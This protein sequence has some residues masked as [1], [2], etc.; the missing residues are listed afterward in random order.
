MPKEGLGPAASTTS[1][2][3]EG[4]GQVDQDTCGEEEVAAKRQRRSTKVEAELFDEIATAAGITRK[5]TKQVFEA[6]QSHALKCLRDKGAFRLPGIVLLT[7]KTLKERPAGVR[8]ANGKEYP[9]R[10]KPER[11]KVTSTTLKG[12]E[13]LAMST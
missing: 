6:L 12:F 13:A 1:R 7:V 4:D 9:L 3:E 11:R 10:P 8:H 5:A 2:D